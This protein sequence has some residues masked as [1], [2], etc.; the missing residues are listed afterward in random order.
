MK[1]S[2]LSLYNGNKPSSTCCLHFWHDKHSLLKSPASAAGKCK[3]ELT[4]TSFVFSYHFQICMLIMVLHRYSSGMS[5]TAKGII[6][7]VLIM[8]KKKRL[9]KCQKKFFVLKVLLLSFRKNYVRN[10]EDCKEARIHLPCHHVAAVNSSMPM[11][12]T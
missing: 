10:K 2:M 1:L 7:M 6:L 9:P 5:P 11:T 8:R 3:P 4:F 12:D